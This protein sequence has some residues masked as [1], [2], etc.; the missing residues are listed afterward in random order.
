MHLI[1]LVLRDRIKRIIKRCRAFP[2]GKIQPGKKMVKDRMPNTNVSTSDMLIK[3]HRFR[4][5]WHKI[6]VGLS[7]VVVFCTTY[8]LILPAI[9]MEKECTLAEHTHE[10]SCYTAETVDTLSCGVTLH[11]HS[12][13]CFDSDGGLVCGCGDFVLHTHDSNCFDAAGQLVCALPE[14]REHIH[15]DGCYTLQNHTHD[16]DSCWEDV[17]GELICILE[18]TPAHTHD[19]VCSPTVTELVCGWEETPE[20]TH[21]ES[22]YQQRRQTC[23]LAETPG[24]NHTEDCWA[25][26]RVLTCTTAQEEWVLTCGRREASLHSHTEGCYDQAGALICGKQQ[27]L[28][29]V[30]GEECFQKTETQVMTCTLEEHTHSD[31]CIP[32]VQEQTMPADE[33]L[34][35]TGGESTEESGTT[36]EPLTLKPTSATLSYKTQEGDWTEITG[37]ETTIPGNASFRL[38]VGFSVNIE[39]LKNANYQ[40]IYSP[41]PDIF[42]DVKATDAIKDDKNNRVGTMTVENGRVLLTF[43][44]EWE[45]LSDDTTLTGSFYVEAKADLSKIPDSGKTEIVVGNTTIKVNFDSDL[46]AKYGEVTL[47]KAMGTLEENVTETDG[48]QRDYITYTLKVTAG[49]D[50]CPQVK[51]EDV[52]TTGSK[53]IDAY[54][55]LDVPQGTTTEIADNKTLT[56]S[57][58]DMQPGEVK[59]LTYK[60]RLTSDYLGVHPKEALTNLAKVYSKTYERTTSSQTFA[61]QGKATMSKMASEYIPNMDENGQTIPGG[62]IRYTVWVHADKGNNY[63]LENV[64]IWD[65]LDGSVD[66][67]FKNDEKLLPYLSYDETSFAYYIGGS[68]EQN[69]AGNLQPAQTT[70]TP[71][72]AENGKSF[73]FNV[74]N[75]PPGESRLLIYTVKVD[76][77]IFTQSNETITV[78]NRA[79]IITDP[80][81]SDDPGQRLESYKQQKTI[82]TKKWAR[83]I[84]GEQVTEETTIPMGDASFLVPKDSYKYQVVVNEDGDWDVS[85]ATMK[86]DLHSDNMAFVGCVRVD[87]Y[88]ITARANVGTDADAAKRLEAMTPAATQ[89]VNIDGKTAFEFTPKDIGLPEGN[90]AYL[91]TYY[92]QPKDMD[93]VS[94]VIVAN[95]FDLTGT[96]GVGGKYYILRGIKVSATVQLEGSNYFAAS[97][98]FW[99]YDANAQMEEDAHGAMYWVI[100]LQGN[101]IPGQTML[102]DSITEGPHRLGSLERAFVC[103]TVED[104]AAYRD[105]A[106]LDAAA[107]E[108]FTAYTLEKTDAGLQLTLTD[109]VELPQEH[110]LYFIVS[111]YPTSVPQTNGTSQ[112]YENA[113]LTKDPGDNI[114]W[115]HQSEDRTYLVGGDV[116]YKSMAEAF[117]VTP[118]ATPEETQIK[119]VAGDSNTVL[120][121]DYLMKAGG[122]V[123]VAW[124]V[125]INH[126]A[127]LS[128][129]YRVTEHIPQGMEVVYIQRYSTAERPGPVFAECEDLA[130]WTEVRQNF[131]FRDGNPTTAIYYVNGQSV[132][133]DIADLSANPAEPNSRYAD[134]LVVCKVTDSDLFL[135]GSTKTYTN[136][137]TLQ[138]ADG[139][140]LGKGS[141]DVELSY[142]SLSKKG[143]YNSEVNGGVYPFEIQLNELGVDLIPGGTTIKLID[144]MCDVLILNPSSI[145]VI[146]TRTQENVAFTSA[147]VGQTLTL[148]L[149]D[150]QPLT[151]TYEATINAAPGDKIAISNNAH[152]EGYATTPGGSVEVSDFS[153]SVGAVVGTSTNPRL[154][155]L[156]VDQYNTAQKLK[157]ATFTLT[158]MELNGS[159]FSEKQGGLTLTGTTDE[160][161]TIVFGE[162]DSE[163]KLACNTPYRLVETA[164][165]GGYVLDGTPRYIVFAKKENGTYPEELDAFKQAGAYIQYGT[166][167]TYTAYNHK[168]EILVEK[169]FQNADG[170]PL[171]KVDGTYTF[172]LFDAPDAAAPVMTAQLKWANGGVYPSDGKA[173]FT[174]LELGKTYYV[175]ELND[176]GEPILSGGGTVSGMPFQVSYDHTEVTVSADSSTGA[177]KVTNRIDYPELPNTGGAGTQLYTAGGSLLTLAATLL[178]YNRRKRRREEGFPG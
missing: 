42:R 156:K 129:R 8:A 69:G 177:V 47:E 154:T 23:D 77:R 72:F 169:T 128:G 174:N 52:F 127:T 33:V 165:P 96:V 149:P 108:K 148:T 95:Q 136:Q 34:A 2:V 101:L 58:G 160:D 99:Y 112:V 164:A 11:S 53:Y 36:G 59:I 153:Y 41:L 14:I 87:A 70:E 5:R 29:H 73:H 6:L 62:S 49:P 15:T 94:S 150:D 78:N 65:S 176:G 81:R 139:R 106:A 13:G 45:G 166:E 168:G 28:A 84:L 75:L 56:W 80:N 55:L 18:E 131:T 152:W 89:W 103:Q 54:I 130:G 39:N 26:E 123:Y 79:F 90:Y 48:S 38:A 98:R 91:L 143:T 167:Y 122:G 146:N 88:E 141:A 63:T 118:G 109:P 61:P 158:E 86:D 25:R 115:V 116:I 105:L 3:K 117:E 76:P 46:V 40:M 107:P 21:E 32:V 114:Q 135:G 142:P 151:I 126:T 24:H 22:C 64:N 178:L 57:I 111:T 1:Y 113:L 170:S 147:I 83:K 30:H 110:S 104:F 124:R 159:V 173:H 102:L 50:G 120:Q 145:K 66:G 171:G 43:N 20:H 17:G 125:N 31:S 93:K 121:N 12:S 157:G 161:G 132:I 175:Y 35:V 172:G 82:T 16:Q 144:Q 138:T 162:K 163:K 10:E 37:N 68:K 155:I 134:Y 119:C 140:Q 71:R 4:N 97:K 67:S 51:V 44:P 60:V 27:I 74:G 100:R 137:V 85:S 92:A 9:T 19:E 7:S 133:W